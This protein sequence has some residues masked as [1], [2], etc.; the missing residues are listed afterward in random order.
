M[1]GLT[2]KVSCAIVAIC[3][4]ARRAGDEPVRS[5]DLNRRQGVPPRYLEAA[6]QD[7]VRA[8]ILVGIRGRRG[9]YR[10]VGNPRKITVAHIALAVEGVPLEARDDQALPPRK[11]RGARLP[12]H[13]LA[14]EWLNCLDR[15][16]VAQLMGNDRPAHAK[17]RVV[18]MA[19]GR[20]VAREAY[21]P[22]ESAA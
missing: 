13:D 4:L 12:P 3:D 6:L 22:R 11:V 7:L 10:L 14:T 19:P 18:A 20:A 17:R 21:S 15:I 16:T 9:G 5:G 2:R 8:G 1:I